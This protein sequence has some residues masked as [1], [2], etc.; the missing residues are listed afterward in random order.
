MLTRAASSMA[1]KTPLYWKRTTGE[2]EAPAEP[3]SSGSAGA[4][5]SRP[6]SAIHAA[7]QVQRLPDRRGDPA[8]LRRADDD[9]I[10]DHLD[11]VL[12]AVV[13]GRHLLDAV[14]LAVHPDADEPRLARLVEERL[15]A[16]LALP[17]QRRQQV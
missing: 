10:D 15:V 17:L 14:G 13:D 1:G 7:A 2:G 5:P 6:S 16:L 4:S 8:A 12:A 3:S 11:S 9:A